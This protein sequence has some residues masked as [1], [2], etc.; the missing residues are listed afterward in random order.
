M[1]DQKYL[2]DGVYVGHDGYQL[3]LSVGD[4]KNWSIA[5]EPKVLNQL[6][7]YYNKLKKA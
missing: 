4:N 7:E 6:I 2:G 3:W 1:Q 5:L